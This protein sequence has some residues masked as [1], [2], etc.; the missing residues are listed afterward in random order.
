MIRTHELQKAE[1]APT[2]AG[3]PGR[4]PGERRLSVLV[5]DDE[6]ESR[7]AL[8]SA[9][10]ALGHDVRVAC[11]ADE[12]LRLHAV[13]RPD[14]IVSDFS[15][16]EMDG[17]ELCRRIRVADA[18]TGYTYFIFVTAFADKDHFVRGMDAGA[19]DYQTKP[20]D[21]DELR[22]RLVSAARVITLHRRLARSNAALRR[23][24]EQ[25]FQLARV[26]ALTG[27]G[28]RLRMMEDLA[29][30]WAR[31]RRYE[32]EYA[33]AI[34][35]VDR[36]KEYNDH[37]GHLAGDDVLRTIALAI[38]GAL[39]D[40]DALYRYGGEEFLVVLPRQSIDDAVAAMNRVRVAVERLVV[41][42]DGEASNV[43]VSVGVA[44]LGEDDESC[45]DWMARADVALYAAKSRGRNRVE[46]DGRVTQS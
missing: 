2:A 17:A 33:L 46:A 8:A 31:A 20:I 28:N 34:C 12:A 18:D 43:T 14:V 5:V 26:D 39:R 29:A 23:D 1:G 44:S 21:V 13:A 4:A 30:L 40:G 41:T 32:E 45:E 38:R 10:R 3:V 15:M 42:K 25:S 36:F 16:P 7:R 35:D 24:S 6:E 11:D 19:D 9:I 37:Y 27:I 22:A